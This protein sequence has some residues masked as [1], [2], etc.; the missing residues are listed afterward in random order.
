MARQKFDWRS[1]GFAKQ[2][3]YPSENT[4]GG[5]FTWFEAEVTPPEFARQVQDFQ[6]STG[7][8]GA[9]APPSVGGKH[10]GKFTI[11]SALF[12]LKSN[13][14][15]QAEEPG[16]SGILSPIAV[17]LA[18]ALGS[19][20]AGAAVTNAATFARGLG[21][22][23]T[24]YAGGSIAAS[25]HSNGVVSSTAT[26]VTVAVGKGAGYKVGQFVVFIDGAASPD[27]TPV[28]G[29]IKSI[30]GD[31]LTLSSTNVVP[32][33]S[34]THAQANDEGL[35]TAVGFTAA[36]Q[37]QPLTF[38]ILGDNA[39][40]KMALIGCVARTIKITCKA[41][42][43]PQVEIGYEF[44]EHAMYST[45]GGLQALSGA[46]KKAQA[47]IGVNAGWLG[48]G[49]SGSVPAVATG[50]YDVEINIEKKLVY[51]PAHSKNQGVG[52]FLC[53]DFD[54]KVSAVVPRDSSD[55]ISNRSHIWE[56]AFEDGD[57]K[58]LAVFGGTTPGRFFGIEFPALHIFS[59]P[60]LE[61]RDGMVCDKIEFRP[62]VYSSDGASTNAGN[63]VM[64]FGIG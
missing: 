3:D 29:F 34:S 22:A 1:L 13:Y 10:G 61:L 24:D 17:L 50:W 57:A 64:R 4:T 16:G 28:M 38:Q 52:E 39:G 33:T 8:V 6:Y 5:D 59:Q 53:S 46:Y 9:K 14:N 7:Q 42:E 27:S 21:M 36:D 49:A 35:G 20:N 44:T 55:T 51:V 60:M 62:G 26:T 41:G 30:A 25:Y 32:A 31:V 58:A 40:H 63:K 11:K 23:R 2:A 37:E 45:G 48:Y 19:A 43:V 56:K 18:N 15:Y 47:V 54:I 12:C